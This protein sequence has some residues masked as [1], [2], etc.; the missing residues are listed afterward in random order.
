MGHRPPWWARA[1]RRGIG[2]V[3]RLRLV[4]GGRLYAATS[5]PVCFA[6]IA[7]ASPSLMGTRHASTWMAPTPWARTLA[8]TVPRRGL[9]ATTHGSKAGFNAVPQPF[10]AREPVAAPTLT[11]FGN[12]DAYI[13]AIESRISKPASSIP[14]AS[15]CHVRDPPK[16][17]RCPPG[18][19]IL[20]H[21]DAHS[22]HHSWKLRE[23]ASVRLYRPAS[24]EAL[25]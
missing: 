7:A 13:Q 14:A 22:V 10:H 20:M 15:R 24:V 19:R 25:R 16:A 23:A 12:P 4:P 18:L 1:C 17:R 8:A 5:I 11:F 2:R 6:L 21:S 9:R 3:L